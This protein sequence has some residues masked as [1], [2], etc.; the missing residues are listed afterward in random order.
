MSTL[1]GVYANQ[2]KVGLRI[3]NQLLIALPGNH[4]KMRETS[5]ARFNHSFGTSP[6]PTNY[7]SAFRRNGSTIFFFVMDSNA[8][9][10]GN[11]ARG[12]IDQSRLSW[13][14]NKLYELSGGVSL[15]GERFTA[16]ECEHSIRCL[17]LHHHVYP[18]SWKRRY[19]NLQRSFTELVG[20]D[21]L[22]KAISG[23]IHLILHGHEHYPTHFVES[24]SKTLVI[25]AGTTSQ[26]QPEKLK[27]SFYHLTFFTDHS[28][29]IDE[30]VWKGTGFV[31]RQELQG[32]KDPVVY[33]LPSLS[34][35]ASSGSPSL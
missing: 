8:Y 18:L 14:L 20:A 7:V 19:F 22:L 25:S 29:Q 2:S 34:S 33:Q 16:D 12:E 24:T 21:D 15:D 30:F 1:G 35:V 5:L 10:E 32:N 31:S 23:R 3:P 13:L 4:D 9:N 27:N 28:I 17:V 11:I 26:W 6:A